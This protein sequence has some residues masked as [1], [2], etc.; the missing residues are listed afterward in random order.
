MK[1]F[2]GLGNPGKQYESTRHNVGFM[3]LD[4]FAE[5]AGIAFRADKCRALV[6]HGV[7][8][9]QKVA[10]VKPQ[11][12]MNLS[13]EAVRAFMDY[14]K[15]DPADLILLYDD[16]DLPFGRL[17]LRHQG[18]AGGHNGVK[19]VI[20]HLGTERFDRIRIG[21]SRPPEGVDPADYVLS[22]FSQEESRHLD[23]LLELV[24]SAMEHALTHPFERT[25]QEF[26]G[27]SAV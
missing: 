19:S 27:R 3:A 24:V 10:L 17:R 2:V 13:G 26:N 21:I 5:K 11:T 20:Q 9:G 16:L 14:Y 6:G 7:V 8:A 23:A 1:W 15:A 4:R 12:Y 22:P 25:M 18:S